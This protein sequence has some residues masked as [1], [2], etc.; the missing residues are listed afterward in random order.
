MSLV[1]LATDRKLGRPV[2]I[3]VVAPDLA[4]TL[5][6]ERFAREIQVAASLQQANIV[7]LLTAGEVEGI[8]YFTMPY[9]EGE[10]LRARLVRGPLPEVEAIS[11]L[12]DVARALAYAHGRGIVH[13]D[14][15]PDNVLLSGE[16]A[17]VTDFGIAKALRAFRQASA[18]DSGGLEMP[19]LHLQEQVSR[20]FE[21]AGQRD[22]AVATLRLLLRPN[23][24]QG[25]PMAGR[26]WPHARRRLGA[27][28]ET[29]GR[30][31]EAR[32]AYEQFVALWRNADPDLQP[33]V[34]EI[35][36]R[37]AALGGR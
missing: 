3:K 30:P 31:A 5:S 16:A 4:A 23:D 21:A 33:Q 28:E 19:N 32:R 25:G 36:A 12:R 35:R 10:S 26:I 7:P 14:I 29:L 18:A 1:F 8:P 20:A 22:S 2:V 24:P 27:L 9:V 37:L 13:R 34:A 11:I 17:V 15:K 6:S